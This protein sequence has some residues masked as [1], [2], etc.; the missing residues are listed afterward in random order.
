MGIHANNGCSSGIKALC[1]TMAHMTSIAPGRLKNANNIFIHNR[2][3]KE[4]ACFQ[5]LYKMLSNFQLNRGDINKGPTACTRYSSD[6]DKRR[7][8]HTLSRCR[9]AAWSNHMNATSRKRVA[10]DLHCCANKCYRARVKKS[11]FYQKVNVLSRFS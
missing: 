2:D 9:V 10:T 11:Q 3:L 5:V 6:S 1:H 8:R 7:D 4:K